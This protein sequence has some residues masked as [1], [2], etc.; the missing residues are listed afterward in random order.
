MSNLISYYKV[1]NNEDGSCELKAV[2]LAG[3]AQE[4]IVLNAGKLNNEISDTIQYFY[5]KR[6]ENKLADLVVKQGE[7]N[8]N[9]VKD[10]ELDTEIN[11]FR[12]QLEELKKI[13]TP[14]LSTYTFINRLAVS[15]LNEKSFR[16]TGEVELYKAL[17]ING[18]NDNVEMLE[19]S[20]TRKNVIDIMAEML[21]IK[22]CPYLKPL[23]IKLNLKETSQLIAI[24]NSARARWTAKG[25][26]IKTSK[27][28]ETEVAIQSI[29]FVCKNCFKMVVPVKT[30]TDDRNY[31]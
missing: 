19:L 18:N 12:S 16:I 8:R 4:G 6:I 20:A 21:E 29:L 27:T 14:A 26:K 5:N 25:I 23:N 24:A 11:N 31:I 17:K 15:I 2:V 9:G 13:S 28:I 3:I 30:S 10:E 7:N 22:N 1:V